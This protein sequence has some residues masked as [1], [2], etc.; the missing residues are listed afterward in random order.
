MSDELR[1]KVLTWQTNESKARSDLL[2]TITFP[3]DG[4]LTKAKLVRHAEAVCAEELS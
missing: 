1:K 2:R 3:F 4:L